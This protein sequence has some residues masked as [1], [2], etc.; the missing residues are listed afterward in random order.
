LQCQKHAIF[1]KWQAKIILNC[2][3]KMAGEI[4]DIVSPHLLTYSDLHNGEWL[5]VKRDRLG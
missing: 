3:V 1:E 4:L 2:K 5:K